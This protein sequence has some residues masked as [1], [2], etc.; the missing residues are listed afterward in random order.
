MK[1]VIDSFTP[2]FQDDSFKRVIMF[3][4]RSI[5]INYHSCCRR[6]VSLMESKKLDRNR[7]KRLHLSI[8]DDQLR[9]S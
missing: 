6:S 7:C 8:S 3:H 2:Y 9:C 5:F 1:V 4:S